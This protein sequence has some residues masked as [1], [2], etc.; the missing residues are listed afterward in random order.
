MSAQVRKNCTNCEVAGTRLQKGSLNKQD[1][2]TTGAN[3]LEQDARWGPSVRSWL[4]NMNTVVIGV[5]NRFGTQFQTIFP[6]FYLYFLSNQL[7][8]NSHGGLWED[9][10]TVELTQKCLRESQETFWAN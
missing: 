10:P 7:V 1:S 2:D 3:I 8:G 4:K 9:K 5:T 6:S